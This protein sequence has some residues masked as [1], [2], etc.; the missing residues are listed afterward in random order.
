MVKKKLNSAL[1][2]L[3]KGTRGSN[4]IAI[5]PVNEL[6]EEIKRERMGTYWSEKKKKKKFS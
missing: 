2:F 1:D 4:Y 3:L 5:S 6:A